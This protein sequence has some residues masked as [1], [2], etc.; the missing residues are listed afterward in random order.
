MY[1]A[2]LPTLAPDLTSLV[3]RKTHWSVW[4]KLSQ[5][6][7]LYLALKWAELAR[8]NIGFKVLYK[9]TMSKIHNEF[10][11]DYF[12]QWIAYL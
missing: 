2:L 9:R 5:N 3:N 1:T 8:E 11:S 7:W 4:D 12:K 6:I 10:Y